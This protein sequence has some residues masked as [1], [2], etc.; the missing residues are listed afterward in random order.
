[1]SCNLFSALL[2]PI[3]K[4]CVSETL[5]KYKKK[6]KGKNLLLLKL[7]SVPGFRNKLKVLKSQHKVKQC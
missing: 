1:M 5:S 3:N 2:F 7:E 6:R 4:N